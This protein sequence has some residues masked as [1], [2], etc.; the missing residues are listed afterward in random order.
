MAMKYILPILLVLVAAQAFAADSVYQVTS[1]G[2]YINETFDNGLNTSMWFE[3]D[4]KGEFDFTGGNL[5]CQDAN[6]FDGII[7]HNS[8]FLITATDEWNIS[9]FLRLSGGTS[10][11]LMNFG[12]SETDAWTGDDYFYQKRS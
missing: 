4:P 1:N 12:E 2:F 3:D 10:V 8:N 11:G 6:D 9:A 5:N 7:L